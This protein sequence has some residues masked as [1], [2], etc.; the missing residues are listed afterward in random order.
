[1]I[2]K[3]LSIQEISDVY[4]HHLK[5]DFPDNE[6]KPLIVIK[7]LAQ[8][9]LYHCYGLFDNKDSSL[10]AYAFLTR[11]KRGTSL[12]LDY[13]AAVADARGMGYGS[14][15]LQGLRD[16]MPDASGILAEVEH[17]ADGIDPAERE[18]RQR[19]IN[20]YSRNGFSHSRVNGVIFGVHYD[21]VYLPIQHPADDT[22][23]LSQLT[24]LYRSMLPK[25]MFEANVHLE[26]CDSSARLSG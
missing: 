14:Q 3:Q 18:T 6:L 2:I 17:P 20:F 22:F 10:K 24:K 12:L 23:I 26:I 1:M 9:N 8:R 7:N 13:F 19:R 11:A 15:L 4:H 25:F 16:E 5:Y 21:I